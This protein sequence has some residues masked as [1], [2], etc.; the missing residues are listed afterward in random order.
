MYHWSAPAY[1]NGRRLL[2]F[3]ANI[4]LHRASCLISVP[5][6]SV[7]FF[8]TTSWHPM[9]SPLYPF[10]LA[11]APPDSGRQ[12]VRGLSLRPERANGTVVTRAALSLME[13]LLYWWPFRDQSSLGTSGLLVGLWEDRHTA[14][15]NSPNPIL[16]LDQTLLSPLLKP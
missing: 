14:F 7:G 8:L 6:P 13:L 1:N 12:S 9:T 2:H 4:L 16:R 3:V 10:L 15:S 11:T 5:A